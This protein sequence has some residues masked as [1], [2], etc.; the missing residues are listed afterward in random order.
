MTKLGAV[1]GD[2][3]QKAST[4]LRTRSF[5]LGGHVFKVRIPLTK[6]MEAINEKIEKIDDVEAEARFQKMT[7]GFRANHDIEGVLVTEDDVVV[8]GRSTRELVR[9][10][11]TME[12]RIVEYLKLLVPENGSLDE[13]TYEEVEA[14]WPLAIQL[15][16]LA[17]INETI[18][19]GYKESRKN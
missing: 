18:Q 15:E 13:L 14:E 5:E 1:F 3:Y 6:E 16:M 9:T 12:N 19:P 2:S 10:M 8:D 7:T 4:H 17:K 11:M